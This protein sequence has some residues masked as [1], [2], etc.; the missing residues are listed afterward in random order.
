MRMTVEITGFSASIRSI[1]SPEAIATAGPASPP[2]T[3]GARPGTAETME[4]TSSATNPIPAAA[5][6][7]PVTTLPRNVIAAHAHTPS[8]ARPASTSQPVTDGGSKR[9][10]V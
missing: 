2:G 4:R 1:V 7:E 6:V 3:N 8:Q 9:T 10:A 5:A